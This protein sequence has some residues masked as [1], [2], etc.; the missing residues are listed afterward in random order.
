LTPPPLNHLRLVHARDP[1]DPSLPGVDQAEL[2]RRLQRGERAA[3]ALLFDLHAPAIERILLR[4]IGSDQELDDLLHEVF[5]RALQSI[6]RLRDPEALEGWLR[7]L[8]VCA[9]MDLLRSR[10]RRR[11]LRLLPIESVPEPLAPELDEETREAVRI[12]YR[13]LDQLPVEERVAFSLRVLDGMS[14]AEVAAACDCSLATVKRRIARA[15]ATFDH[16]ASTH[17]ALASRGLVQRPLPG[18]EDDP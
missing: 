4:T 13:L 6:H 18:P 12:T 10:S 7:R 11:W 8:A 17:P 1:G 16:A 5:V 14:L 3:A 15:Q 2:L 9:A